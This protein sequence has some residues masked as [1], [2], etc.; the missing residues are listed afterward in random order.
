MKVK[1]TATNLQD[2]RDVKVVHKMEVN[3][4]SAEK[5]IMLKGENESDEQKRSKVFSTEP[6]IIKE[7]RVSYAEALHWSEFEEKQKSVF[8]WYRIDGQVYHKVD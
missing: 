5:K 8:N 2:L 6:E 4:T 1:S 3:V 7:V